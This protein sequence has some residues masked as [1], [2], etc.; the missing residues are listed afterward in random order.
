MAWVVSA[1]VRHRDL[2]PAQVQS[3]LENRIPSL[4]SGGTDFLA[5][6]SNVRVEFFCNSSN[7]LDYTLTCATNRPA[8]PSLAILTRECEPLNEA[9]LRALS[10]RISKAELSY[11]LLEDG[12]TMTHLA[13]WVKSQSPLRSRAAKVSYVLVLI[14][15]AL[16]AVLAYPQLQH[17]SAEARTSGIISLATSIVLPALMIPL[18]F[19][20][21][22]FDRRSLG[23]WRLGQ[24]SG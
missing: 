8:A 18:P 12:R 5:E 16:A 19:L 23:S 21:A 6:Y 11:C 10:G 20:F 1:R 7:I 24:V 9:V 2:E 17:A 22:H 3:A 4:T 15:L 13:S 14:L